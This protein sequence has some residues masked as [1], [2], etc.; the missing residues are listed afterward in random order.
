MNRPRVLVAG[1]GNVFCS[2]DGFGVAVIERLR[3][4]PLPPGVVVADVGIRGLH[5][6]FE[7]LDGYDVL[8]LVDA[9]P[10]GE[11]PGTVSVLEAA[12]DGPGLPLGLDAHGMDPRAVLSMLST[13]GGSVARV[14]VVGCEPATLEEGMGLS[15]PVAAAVDVAARVVEELVS[16]P[17]S[18]TAEH[19]EETRCSSG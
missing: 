10:M 16:T 6:S 5:L 9:L 2:D 13:M 4:R 12:V 18:F 19:G 14:L 3:E 1:V 7:L 17:V 11:R 8:V 15:G